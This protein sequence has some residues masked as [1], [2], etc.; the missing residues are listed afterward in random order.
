MVRF[1]NS[2]VETRKGTQTEDGELCCVNWIASRRQQI[3]AAECEAWTQATVQQKHWKSKL[4][5]WSLIPRREVG[6]WPLSAPSYV[7]VGVYST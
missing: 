6:M 1:K 5:R 3:L 2:E 7:E 4:S